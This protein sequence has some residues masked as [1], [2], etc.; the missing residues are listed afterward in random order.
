MDGTEGDYILKGMDEARGE[1]ISFLDDDDLFTREKLQYVY[2]IFSEHKDLIY[3]H[4]AYLEVD[5]NDILMKLNLNCIKAGN[6]DDFRINKNNN[7]SIIYSLKHLSDFNLSSIS[8]AKSTKNEEYIKHISHKTDTSLFYLAL[9]NNGT[10]YITSKRLTL[11]RF[12][13]STTRIDPEDDNTTISLI[14]NPNVEQNILFIRDYCKGY[15]FYILLECMFLSTQIMQQ[16][17]R[18]QYYHVFKNIGRYFKCIFLLNFKARSILILVYIISYVTKN[19]KL[20][21][22]LFKI[23]ETPK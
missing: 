9:T 19:N 16:I 11:I 20:F 21:S 4:N 6:F 1:I 5:N 18:N 17:V 13:V 2:E 15:P 3:L 8:I 12:H 23:Q 7:K 14:L 10:I 22:T